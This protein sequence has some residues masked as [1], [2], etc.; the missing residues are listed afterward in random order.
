MPDTIDTSFDPLAPERAI[1]YFRAKVS[2]PDSDWRALQ[3]QSNDWAFRMAG[4]SDIDTIE[5]VWS[6]LD[7]AIANGVSFE[8]FKADIVTRLDDAWGEQG[9][10]LETIFRTNVQSSYQAGHYDQAREQQDDRQ[11]GMLDVV[12]DDSTGDICGELDDAIGGQAIDLGDPVWFTVWPPNHFK[13]RTTVITLTR[14]EAVEQ[15]ILTD[16]PEVTVDPDFEGIPGTGGEPDPEDYPDALQDDV[17]R[18]LK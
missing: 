14:E 10:R 6:A 3:N 5:Q 12:E 15:G 2:I 1:E 17:L 11:Y 13:C 4:I 18:F 9:W 7:T 16:V 8:N